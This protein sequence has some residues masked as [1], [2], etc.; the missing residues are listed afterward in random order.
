MAL[1]FEC[2][3]QCARKVLT[4]PTLLEMAMF[5]QLRPHSRLNSTY[6]RQVS[7]SIQLKRNSCGPASHIRASEFLG[8]T[9]HLAPLPVGRHLCRK[10]GDP[11]TLN[12][13]SRVIRAYYLEK[14]LSCSKGLN[15]LC[16]RD[17]PR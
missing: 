12:V 4:L 13:T 17:K 3:L 16:A 11:C 7:A 1:F 10:T 6:T 2:M 8:C 14:E 5:H 9:L 15:V